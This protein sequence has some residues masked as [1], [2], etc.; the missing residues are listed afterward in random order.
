MSN[1]TMYRVV[2]DP[3]RIKEL[4]ILERRVI[5]G[6]R[7]GDEDEEIFLLPDPN[8]LP[9]RVMLSQAAGEGFFFTKEAAAAHLVQ[10]LQEK[11]LHYQ[12]S[13]E[14][15]ASLVPEYRNKRRELYEMSTR[16]FRAWVDKRIDTDTAVYLLGMDQ[17]EAEC[18]RTTFEQNEARKSNP[19]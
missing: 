11:V 13:A 10:N 15:Y 19:A 12:L 5:P 4:P 8:S 17:L 7:F 18:A 3:P 16:I 2:G 9:I 6:G 1:L 14:Q